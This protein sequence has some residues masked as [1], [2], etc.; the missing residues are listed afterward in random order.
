[1]PGKT[2]V[3]VS[4]TTMKLLRMAK[5]KTNTRTYDELIQDLLIHVVR[6]GG[7]DR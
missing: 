6:Y 2:T 4:K 7:G 1:M 5:A 3:Q